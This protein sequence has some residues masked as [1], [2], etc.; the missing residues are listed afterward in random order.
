MGLA[1]GRQPPVT[2]HGVVFRHFA[3]R[4]CG[5]AATPAFDPSI[6]QDRRSRNNPE[7]EFEVENLY[8][9]EDQA[10]SDLPKG[11]DQ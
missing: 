4:T 2:L 1:E 8:D 5:D 7:K 9:H 3:A 6:R 10:S 11:D